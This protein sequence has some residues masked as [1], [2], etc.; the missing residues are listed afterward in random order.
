MQNNELTYFSPDKLLDPASLRVSDRL[1]L[2]RGLEAL[3]IC[4]VS[5]EHQYSRQTL[6]K[7]GDE[8]LITCSNAKY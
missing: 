4:R 1:R 5:V 6:K 8:W 3:G 2:T 7:V